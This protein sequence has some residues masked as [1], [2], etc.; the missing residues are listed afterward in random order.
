MVIVTVTIGIVLCVMWYMYVKWLFNVTVISIF[1]LFWLMISEISFTALSTF[2]CYV[3]LL[4]L[5]MWSYEYFFL[6]GVLLL[7]LVMILDVCFRI[8]SKVWVCLSFYC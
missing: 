5:L 7:Y 8:W 6:I 2:C 3:F 1:P 4:R